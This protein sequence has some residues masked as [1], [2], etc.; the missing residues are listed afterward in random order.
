LSQSVGRVLVVDDD[1]D[2]R[3]LVVDILEGDGYQVHSCPTGEQALEILGEASF[4]LILSDIKMPGITGIELLRHVRKSGLSTMVIL[5][6]AYAS[7]ETAIQALR[8]EAF[9]Y[10]IKP[11][12]LPEFRQRVRQAVQAKTATR[13]RHTVEHYENLSIDHQARRVWVDEH[14]VALTKLEFEVLSHF[15]ECMGRAVSIE[16]LLDKVWGVNTPD[17]CSSDM[18]RSAV[19][20]V[21]RKI[22]DDAREPRYIKN[23]WGVGYQFGP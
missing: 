16:E 19:H 1:K 13:V 6:T 3:I 14:E 5:M 4:D 17:D 12:S 23:V 15:F 7:V 11:F 2:T 20:R 10:L 22:E 18:V 21:R 8:G 9:D